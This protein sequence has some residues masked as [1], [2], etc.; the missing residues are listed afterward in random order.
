[1]CRFTL[2]VCLTAGLLTPFAARAQTCPAN[3]PHVT[4]T[5]VTLPYG[6][7]INPISATL[8]HSGRV[9]IIAGSENDAS[10]NAPGAESYRAAIWD[11]T[12]TTA[13]SISV[14]S[15]TY[16]VFC[17]GTSQLPD[18]RALV[19][20]GTSD[21]SFT[22]DARA[23]I[24]DPV[25][26]RF[27]QSQSMAD[28]RWYGTGVNLGD[29]RVMAFSGLGLSGGTNNTVEIYDL[30][31]AGAGWTSPVTAPFVPPLYPRMVLLPTGR[32]FYTGHG[33][34]S[35]NAQ[36]WMFNPATQVWTS[37][38][39]TDRSRSYGAGVLLSLL[40]PSYTPRVIYF[41]GES[42]ATNTST[43]IDLS[44]ATP[45]WTPGPNMS[46]G[47]IQMNAL[48][49]P[50]GRVLAEG[51]SATNESPSMPG[52]RADLYDPIT[53]TISSA[54][55]ASY[56]RLYHS[57][58]TLL[59][60][61]TVASLGSNPGARGSYQPAIEIYTPP[62]LFDANDQ[63]IVDR[64]VIGSLSSSVLGYGAPFTVSFTAA[65][66]I[67]SAVLVRL[68][69][70]THADDMEQRL[71]GLCGPAPQPACSGSGTL[72][73]TMPPNG[74]VA[75]PGYYMLFLLDS[76]GVP[77]KA[78]FLQLTPYSSAPP[79]GTIDTPA[80]DVTIQAGNSVT[81]STNASAAAYSWVFPG[82]TPATSTARNPGNVTFSSPGIYTASLTVIDSS[83]NTDPS[84]PI[85]TVNVLPRT[86]DFS[87][88]TSPSAVTVAPGQS[89]R[90]TVTVSPQSG[91]T[92]TVS[93]T[94]G[95][96]SGFPAG[97]TSGGFSPASIAGG[98]GTSTLTM[99]TT[100]STSPYALS[101]TITG[102]S[103]ALAHESS[104]TL[105]VNLAAP[106]SLNAVPGDSQVAL[107]WPASVAASGYSVQRGRLSGGPYVAVA[108]PTS[109][110]YTD[111]GLVNG[112][113]YAYV[114]TATYV[115]GPNAGGSS[116]LSPEALAMPAAA[117]PQAPTGLAAATCSGSV[118]LT[119]NASAGATSYR[120]K[121][122][123][124]SGG[125]YGLVGSPTPTSFTDNTAA[126]GSTYFYVVSAVN[127]SGESPNSNEVSA[128]P[129]G[130]AP[131]PPTGLSATFVK[132]KGGSV[133]LAWT[134]SPTAGLTQN[135]V[136]RRTSTGTYGAAL[137]T[138]SPATTY[139]D[140]R[141]AAGTYCYV[142]TALSCRGE[143]VRSNEACATVR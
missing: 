127:G 48:L 126:N 90:F 105:L 128:T 50:D 13:S 104:T 88:E 41:G 49:L 83:G 59:P 23:S 67:A 137:A 57:T 65:A 139:F 51:G 109:T 122:A 141:P 39:A 120:V 134:Q 16:D 42:P 125:P 19:I 84:P 22:G 91:F 55:T 77:S 47:R 28:G 123:S 89:A 114:V 79:T 66:P 3:V 70:T 24:F 52:K 80:A 45:A 108:C 21:Y 142:V 118:S 98:S 53:N 31:N 82:G 56:S 17:S 26:E 12:G 5:W 20:G 81:F 92:G 36:G 76:R 11:P 73:L 129:P 35:S 25:T 9:L 136:Y 130:A 86:A 2:A 44:A 63:P 103:G 97:I 111:T 4:G 124:T 121:R 30:R 60:D 74:N 93:L 112:T 135:A 64:P 72:S 69:S 1:M 101:L 131:A 113:Q 34:G 96:E 61:A 87:I 43:I 115:S 117:V 37:S 27:L 18:G 40:P 32:V 29:G 138:I 100:A 8:L 33:S 10:N 119:W 85:R 68:S 94:V 106:A 116:A 54:G 133:N 7:P 58:A 78:V 140:G 102:T 62:Y 95:S 38:A 75:P 46:S 110:S 132:Q 71:V 14:Q 107:S 143:S 99:N 15:L 6:M